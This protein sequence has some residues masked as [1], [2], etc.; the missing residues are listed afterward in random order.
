MAKKPRLGLTQ[1]H[2]VAV[3]KLVN[4]ARVNTDI[5]SRATCS[6]NRLI[7]KKHDKKGHLV[8][9]RV[10][11]EVLSVDRG[12]YGEVPS[13]QLVPHSNTIGKLCN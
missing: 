8:V 12:L 13:A 1:R 7:T 4:Y 9:V 3:N 2:L 11:V 5:D 10:V 6:E